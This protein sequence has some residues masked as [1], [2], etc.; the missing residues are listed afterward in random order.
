[1]MEGD[2]FSPITLTRKFPADS[3]S[4]NNPFDDYDS[5]QLEETQRQL[6]GGR[7]YSNRLE[8]FDS[9][10][11]PFGLFAESS[12]IKTMRKPSGLRQES[13]AN[14]STE[15]EEDA[16]ETEDSNAKPPIPPRTSVSWL[17]ETF[18]EPTIPFEQGDAMLLQFIMTSLSEDVSF[19]ATVGYDSSS[20]SFRFVQ[21]SS[22]RIIMTAVKRTDGLKS[23]ALSSNISIMLLPADQALRGGPSFVEPYRVAKLR[24][25]TMTSQYSLFDQGKNPSKAA[26]AID[27]RRELLSVKFDILP[28]IY[29]RRATH[30]CLP[31]SGHVRR[32]TSQSEMLHERIKG[33]DSGITSLSPM[34]P[35]SSRLPRL[36]DFKGFA[37]THSVKNIMLHDP[38]TK[39][40]VL[41]FGK[42]DRNTYNLE[43]GAPFSIL[44]AFSV[45]IASIDSRV[46]P[47][48]Q[49]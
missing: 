34:V 45:A 48:R 18:K 22:H 30:V 33:Y 47:S 43:F 29:T 21:D 24:S 8:R 17:R 6:F 2:F 10:E 42:R 46:H 5:N 35:N 12:P 13:R 39:R 41:K 11:D 1:M 14:S 38:I 49:L 27:A 20:K 15:E 31:K 36:L 37:E 19:K 3:V 32:P 26:G 16:G 4:S 7:L 44:S 40:V 23:F 9:E 25:N 28:S